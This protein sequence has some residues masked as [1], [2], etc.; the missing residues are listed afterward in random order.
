MLNAHGN[1]AGRANH[2]HILVKTHRWSPDWDC[3]SADHIFLT[4]RDL[5]GVLASYQRVGWAFNIPNS[6]ISEHMQWRVSPIL[7]VAFVAAKMPELILVPMKAFL[8]LNLL[9]SL[10]QKCSE[11]CSVLLVR[12]R[13]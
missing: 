8:P 3:S 1:D 2:A 4:H 9:G 10:C 11:S 5:R 7:Q 12:C 13:T 6:Y